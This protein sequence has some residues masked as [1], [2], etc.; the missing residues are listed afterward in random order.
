MQEQKDV[1]RVQMLTALYGIWKCNIGTLEYSS[2]FSSIVEEISE[3]MWNSR[4]Q[5][6]NWM[7]S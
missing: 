1:G 4:I 2:Y 7:Q 6:E 5:G 3:R